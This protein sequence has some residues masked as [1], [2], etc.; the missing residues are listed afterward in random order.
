MT[1]CENTLI[2]QGKL[3]MNECKLDHCLA[4]CDNSPLIVKFIA[5][6]SKASE[7]IGSG[8]LEQRGMEKQD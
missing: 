6:T 8:I 1:Y 5:H 3:A 7:V 2:K 4:C